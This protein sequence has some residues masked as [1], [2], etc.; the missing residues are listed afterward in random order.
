MGQRL[1][2]TWNHPDLKVDIFFRPRFSAEQTLL[3][4]LEAEYVVEKWKWV[5]VLELQI[6][7]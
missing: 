1:C 6:L 5:W 2:Q 4:V 7:Y 3:L